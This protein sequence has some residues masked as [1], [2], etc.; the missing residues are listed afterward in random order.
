M[1]PTPNSRAGEASF[2][3]NP[4]SG[5]CRLFDIEH[6]GY[7]GFPGG[8]SGKEPICQCG[9]QKRY[10]FNSWVGKIPGRRTQQPI[11]VFLPGDSHGQRHLVGYSPW[12][13]KEL[14]VTEV[15]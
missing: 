2:A 5:F 9:R 11:L 1:N 8:A 4:V 6:V 13:C 14:N 12:G 15:T 3:E 7:P 10:G